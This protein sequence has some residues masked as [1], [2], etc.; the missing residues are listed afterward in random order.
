M[1]SIGFEVLLAP[2][3]DTGARNSAILRLLN[4]QSQ[5]VDGNERIHRYTA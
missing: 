1:P 4:M 2:Y 3:Q 5:H